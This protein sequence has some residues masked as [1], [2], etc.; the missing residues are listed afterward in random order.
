MTSEGNDIGLEGCA[1]LDDGT[2]MDLT[3]TAATAHSRFAVYYA[4]SR[5][6]GWWDAGCDWLGRDPESGATRVPPTLPALSARARDVATLSRAARR[7][8]WHGT[9]VAPARCAA[10]VE[11]DDVLCE[12]RAWAQ[13]QSAFELPVEVAPLGQ[14]VAV[15]P[16][17]SDGTAAIGAVAA[18]ALRAFAPLRAMPN[19]AERR[20]RLESDL[21]ARQ[22]ELFDRWGYP[23]VLEEF[24]FHMTLSDPI[25]QE[26]RQAMLAWWQ[27]R[28]A[29]LGPL[30]IDSVALFV[31]PEPG[32]PFVLWARVPFGGNR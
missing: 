19:E 8:G 21:S 26:D 28:V 13:R 17:T 3:G 14:F 29:N 30:R 24:R 27:T 15:R 2:A 9:L 32:A 12:A 25:D 7:Y 11:F 6:S 22:R 31:E 1:P 16:A 20:R 4:P 23:Y 18:D 5:D 10:N